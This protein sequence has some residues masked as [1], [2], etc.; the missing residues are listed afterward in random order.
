MKIAFVLI[1]A[2]RREGT[3][4]AVLEVAERL[5][6]DHEVHLWAR[7]A[8]DFDSDRIRWYRLPGPSRPEVA[9]F[10]SFKWLADRRL[11]HSDYDIIHSAGPNTAVADVYAVQTVQ[12][13]KVR[14]CAPLRAQS[15]ASAARRLSWRTYDRKVIAAER[16]AYQAR[17]PRG[18]RAF[19]PVSA[20][21]QSELMAEYPVSED[22]RGGENVVVIPNGADLELFHPENRQRHRS[23][24]RREFGIARD[25]FLLLFS[26]GDWRRKGLD[27]AIE[28]LAKLNSP[29]TKLLVAGH[30][31]AGGDIRNL[32]CRLGVDQ[33][34]HFAGFRPDV[35]RCYAAGDLFLFPTAYEAFSLSTIEAA[36]SGL[37]VL[38]S[39]VSGAAELVGSGQAGSIIRRQAEHIAEKIL[40]YRDSPARLSE[41]GRAGRRIVEQRFNW[42]VVAEQ[43]LRVYERLLQQRGAVLVS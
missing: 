31:R 5:A 2:N 41:A 22:G 26:G 3:G 37:P 30:D 4:R 1:N 14:Q 11:R 23:D 34:V 38:M 8:T 35:H 21:T 32:P 42:D 18:R 40:E 9:D 43:T 17:G 20:G 7:T 27:L 10:V 36:A 39:D 19:L 25:D 12:P 24:V 6:N 33:Q 13:V 29:K 15:S 28:A 16:Q